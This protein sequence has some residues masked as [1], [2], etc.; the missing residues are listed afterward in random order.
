MLYYRVNSSGFT[1]KEENWLK[2]TLRP[3]SWF[4]LFLNA[5]LNSQR[6]FFGDHIITIICIS[7]SLCLRLPLSLSRFLC[8]C[9]ALFVSQTCW[10]SPECPSSCPMREATTSSSRWW[11]TTNLRLLVRQSRGSGEII[12]TICGTCKIKNKIPL[13]FQGNK[14]SRHGSGLWGRSMK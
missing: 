2:L 8:L 10:R 1:S 12:P 3:V 4:S 13:Q 6:S 14:T 7:C 5:F 9:L 11:P